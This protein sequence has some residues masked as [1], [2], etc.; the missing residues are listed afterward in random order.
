MSETFS[1]NRITNN[2]MRSFFASAA[3][4]AVS[5]AVTAWLS[6]G[7]YALA[8]LGASST[9][10]LDWP[11]FPIVDV[12]AGITAASLVAGVMK[13]R[14]SKR[15]IHSAVAT[16][17]QHSYI[18]CPHCHVNQISLDTATCTDCGD[19]LTDDQMVL[20]RIDRDTRMDTVRA[21][22]TAHRTR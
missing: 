10:G 14:R 12:L 1:D 7:V 9:W 13:Y 18:S 20:A 17:A 16:F 22:V 21:I 11:T 3:G 4:R 5:E 2:C 19:D 15:R 6:L 8:Y